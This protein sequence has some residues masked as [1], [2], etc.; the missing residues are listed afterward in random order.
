MLFRSPAKIATDFDEVCLLFGLEGQTEASMQSDIETGLSHFKRVCINIMTENTTPIKPCPQ[1]I[2]CFI[3][4]L[5]PIY[6]E[7]AC[8]DILLENTDFGVG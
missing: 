6:K 1:V 8:V 7:N 4:K 2:A 3:K 5:Y